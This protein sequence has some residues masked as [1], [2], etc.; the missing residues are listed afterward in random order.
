[1]SLLMRLTTRLMTTNTPLEQRMEELENRL[2][3]YD[4]LF[5]VTASQL[6][7][8]QPVVIKGTLGIGGP[9]GSSDNEGAMILVGRGE[10]D[11]N[12]LVA[13]QGSLFMRTDGVAGTTLWTNVN[14]ASNWD[15]LN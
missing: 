10:P 5:H 9:A 8:Q 1:M 11:T 6:V 14:G 4:R 13:P 3:A 12:G 2:A 7:I 15:E